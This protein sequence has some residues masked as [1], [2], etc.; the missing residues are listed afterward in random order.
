MKD[1]DN[2]QHQQI[3]AGIQ[4][5]PFMIEQPGR[6][7]ISIQ[8]KRSY[9]ENIGQKIQIEKRPVLRADSMI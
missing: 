4:E 5:I 6:Q 8:I 7:Q 3:S 1:H 2:T 9:Q